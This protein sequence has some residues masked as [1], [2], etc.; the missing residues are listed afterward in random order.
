M[1]VLDFVL[2]N[3]RSLSDNNKTEGF[4]PYQSAPLA[5]NQYSKV[6]PEETEHCQSLLEEALERN[7]FLEKLAATSC[8]LLYP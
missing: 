6:R 1:R 2:G 3:G 5:G 8:Q 7:M 4:T